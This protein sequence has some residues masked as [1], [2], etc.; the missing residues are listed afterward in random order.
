M[1]NMKDSII[2]ALE[3]DIYDIAGE[4]FNIADHV[5]LDVIMFEKFRALYWR[6]IETGELIDFLAGFGTLIEHVSE[7][8]IEMKG[9]Q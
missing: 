5:Q 9:A 3:N 4:E 6:S 8:L 2:Q 1:D 7:W